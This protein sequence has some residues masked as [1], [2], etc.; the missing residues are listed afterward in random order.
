M[1]DGG[2]TAFRPEWC[3]PPTA[4]GRR[5]RWSNNAVK[6]ALARVLFNLLPVPASIAV[7]IANY[8]WR[9]RLGLMQAFTT[10]S[11]RRLE[12]YYAWMTAG[13]PA[14]RFPLECATILHAARAYGA[15][16]TILS[17]FPPADMPAEIVQIAVDCLFNLQR[18]EDAAVLLADFPVEHDTP[19]LVIWR[20]H[21]I[22]VLGGSDEIAGPLLWSAGQASG[23]NL[24]PHQNLSSRDMPYHAMVARGL[25]TYLPTELDVTAGPDGMLYDACNYLGQKVVHVGSGHLSGRLYGRALAAQDRLRRRLPD[26][27]ARLAARLNEW[28]CDLDTLRLAPPE[29]SAQIGHLGMLDI[30]LRMRTLGWWQGDLIILARPELIANRACLALFAKFAR[31]VVCGEDLPPQ[32]FAELVSLQR[33]AGLAFNGWRLPDGVTVP[34]Q[35]AGALAMREWETR[36][37]GHPLRDAHDAL[38]AAT[39]D[40]T[41]AYAECRRVWGMSP[42]DWYVCLHMRDSSWYGEPTGTGQTHRNAD[43]TA[44]RDALDFVVAQGGW[45]VRMGGANS[46]P[47]PAM[48]HVIDYARSPFK[49]A[50]L[51]LHLIRHARYFIGTTSGLTNIAVSFGIS[52]ALVNCISTD[53]QLWSN[54]VRFALKPIRRRD[55]SLLGQRE[56][57]I[58]PDRWAQFSAETLAPSGLTPEANSPEEILETVRE[59]HGQSLSTDATPADIDSELMEQWRACLAFPHFYG[60]GLPCHYIQERHRR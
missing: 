1:A 56:L 58:A 26:L 21:M 25:A 59:V 54:S 9:G 48:P 27:S 23:D 55:G 4:V 57:T 36:G 2:M 38:A 14:H 49:T 47:L 17:R 22:L 32:E 34:W 24:R 31:V 15:A 20:A 41:A 5:R 6:E 46:A 43:F 37:L 39:P 42:D 45:V 8:R 35:E 53:A 18:F 19:E 11:G 33:Y 10:G 16:M 30:L 40:L 60:A 29:W 28:G 51:D 13:P 50:A 52:C 7:L 44:Y 3:R 12:K